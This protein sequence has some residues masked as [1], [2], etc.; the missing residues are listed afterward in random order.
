MIDDSDTP[1]TRGQNFSNLPSQIA[2]DSLEN[3]NTNL[4]EALLD[5]ER[6][7]HN[8]VL[9]R[10]YQ[11]A[12]LLAINVTLFAD[13]NV[14]APNMSAIALEFG[15]TPAEKDKYLGGYVALSFFCV[16][17]VS[18][19][20]GGFIA[21]KCNRVHSLTAVVGLNGAVCLATYFVANLTQ[22]TVLRALTGVAVGANVPLVF[23]MLGDLF[24]IDSRARMSAITSMTMGLGVGSGQILSGIA[25]PAFGWRSPFLF[26]SIPAF[27]LTLLLASTTK[28]P[29]RGGME[30]SLS[31]ENVGFYELETEETTA[32]LNGNQDGTTTKVKVKVEVSL[33]R[34]KQAFQTSTVVFILLQSLPA[35]LPWGV[36]ITFFNDFAAQNLGIGVEQS[37]SLV[38][39]F[40]LG[41][42]LGIVSAGWAADKYLEQYPIATI[43]FCATSTLISAIPMISLL[44]LPR[45][46]LWLY[47]IVCFPAGMLAGAPT[48]I[49]RAMLLNTTVPEVRGSAFAV[50]NIFDDIGRGLGPFLVSLMIAAMPGHR[51]EALALSFSFWF[52]SGI[53]LFPIACKYQK[54]REAIDKKILQGKIAQKALLREFEP[55]ELE[56]R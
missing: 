5:S 10:N 28:E 2:E 20:I 30:V 16:G 48:G 17:A 47:L 49:I 23:S 8:T 55:L 52:L 21:D 37:T 25:G 1:G 29:L 50:L 15:L 40:G 31:E 4:D 41:L 14:L 32:T 27:V 6:L 33:Q 22:F 42:A 12:L 43:S 13:Q 11:T 56:L 46:P 39:A 26:I 44:F 3:D 53:L 19:F 18:S 45:Q 51:A 54:D 7:S 9:A 38:V 24:G 34:L 35:S 36:I